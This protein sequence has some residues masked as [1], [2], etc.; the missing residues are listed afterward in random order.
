MDMTTNITSEMV[1]NTQLSVID[2][3]L[4]D[5]KPVLITIRPDNTVKATDYEKTIKNY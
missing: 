5:H 3:V 4:A 2:K 1:E